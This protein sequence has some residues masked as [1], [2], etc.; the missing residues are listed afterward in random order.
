MR[1][2]TA[3]NHLRAR[4][5]C[6]SYVS[7]QCRDKSAAPAANTWLRL[8]AFIFLYSSASLTVTTHN[9]ATKMQTQEEDCHPTDLN[10]G[11]ALVSLPGEL[12]DQIVV[13]LLHKTGSMRDLRLT[14]RALN[15]KTKDIFAKIAFGHFNV[16]LRN[17][18]RL[19]KVSQSPELAEHIRSIAF[20]E[21]EFVRTGMYEDALKEINSTEGSAK[22]H[23]DAQKYVW[24]VDRARGRD[25]IER[26]V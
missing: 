12:M 3:H 14:C 2:D 17:V 26:R 7:R 4:D 1:G 25:L 19:A 23:F 22:E 18:L 5:L 21:L 15:Q 16:D 6:G 13:Q 10:H 24:R 11:S 8:L 9:P 20:V